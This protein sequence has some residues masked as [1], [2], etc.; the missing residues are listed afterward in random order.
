MAGHLRNVPP[1]SG[2]LVRKSVSG[3]NSGGMLPVFGVRIGLFLRYTH[4]GM[5]RT[6]NTDPDVLLQQAMLGDRGALIDLLELVGPEIRQRITP[7]INGH[8][9]TSFDE[10]DVMQITYIEAMT[11]LSRFKGGGLQG[12]TAW[13]TRLA[14]NNLID[15]VRML[16]A[17]KRPNPK[18]RVNKPTAGQD[19]MIAL[20]EIV[21]V[22]YITPSS[23]AARGEMKSV[24]DRVLEML[25]SDYAQVVRLYDLQQLSAPKVARE[26]G[27][28]EGAVYML[29]ARA[30]DRLR[31]LL[32]SE[33]RIFSSAS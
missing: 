1:D 24:L 8:L 23:V 14:E 31:E 26:M 30:H 32:P 17:S 9:R 33:S 10:D 22:T 4:F 21:G 11:K 28:T 6:T 3:S 25:P 5:Q 20:V 29:R 2:D 16:E 27:R 12:F 18:K 7:R 19:C 15:A 13:M